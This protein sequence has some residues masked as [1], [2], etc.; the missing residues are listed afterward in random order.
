MNRLREIRVL[1]RVTQYELRLATGM[2][3]SKISLI[4]NGFVEPTVGEMEKLGCALGVSP[5]EIW[6]VDKGTNGTANDTIDDNRKKTFLKAR[7]VNK[8]TPRE[9]GT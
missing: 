6:R 1:K 9:N 7:L 4:E 8:S 3:Q 2:H 5:E